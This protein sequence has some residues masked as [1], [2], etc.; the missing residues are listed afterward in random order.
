MIVGGGGANEGST[1][2]RPLEVTAEDAAKG[3]DVA[4]SIRGTIVAGA[5]FARP[6]PAVS[7]SV[8]P[9]MIASSAS[10]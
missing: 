7:T 3:R 10:W 5:E 2:D 8:V 6:H 9:A 4:A 1:G